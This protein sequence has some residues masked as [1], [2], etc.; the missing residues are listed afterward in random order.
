MK[1]NILQKDDTCQEKEPAWLCAGADTNE[2]QK[3]NTEC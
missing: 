3:Q 1:E 2:M